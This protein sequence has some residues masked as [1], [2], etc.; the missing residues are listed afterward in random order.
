[1][2][3]KMTTQHS[4]SL[5][6]LRE[7]GWQTRL[8]AEPR[9][10]PPNVLNRYPWLP[11]GWARF[12]GQI[13]DVSNASQAQ[14]LLGS[15]DY[16]EDQ[17]VPFSWNAWEKLCLECAKQD[18]DDDWGLRI[19]K[20]WDEH[21]PIAISVGSGYAYCALRKSDL[22]VVHGIEPDFEDVSVFAEDLTQ[23]LMKL[24]DTW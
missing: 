10:M 13:E 21:F 18:G 6:R 11:D 2:A 12:L 8:F 4:K 19:R 5:E 15:S 17:E 1:M 20:F 3:V 24:A 16:A 14:W 7:Q 23:L 22:R 9:L